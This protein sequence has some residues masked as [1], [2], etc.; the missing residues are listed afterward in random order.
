M[1]SQIISLILLT[2]LFL[3]SQ[4]SLIGSIVA[5]DDSPIPYA[6]IAIE[7]T[8][9]GTIANAVGK[10]ELKATIG[11]TL[12]ISCLGFQTKRVVVDHSF[13]KIVL[14]ELPIQLQ[15]VLVY[16]ELTAR[17]VIAKAIAMI[18]INYDFEPFTYRFYG[19]RENFYSQKPGFIHEAVFDIYSKGWKYELLKLRGKYKEGFKPQFDKSRTIW[20]G[21]ID[22][23]FFEKNPEAW[24]LK[25]SSLSLFT[26]EFVDY[27]LLDGR[28]T[29]IIKA[30]PNE[31]GLQKKKKEQTYYVDVETHA[32][33]KVVRV[34]GWDVEIS[35]RKEG[36][37]WYLHSYFTVAN[38]VYKR[39]NESFKNTFLVTEVIRG[40][41]STIKPLGYQVVEEAKFRMSDWNSSFWED[42][43]YMV[44]D[45]IW[46]N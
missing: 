13:L 11:S 31:K 26:Y 22:Y 10:F 19:L 28:P 2:P 4:V 43:N 27:V 25:R 14:T 18:P 9:R 8:S 6:S 12:I 42:Y 17:D 46:K 39:E 30:T 20:L 21:F 3:F 44:L 29:N 16:S 33:A 23:Q 40:E 45:E 1:K 36:D 15:E 37:K 35:Y 7:G 32:I 41:N 34:G 24:A 5:D 38:K